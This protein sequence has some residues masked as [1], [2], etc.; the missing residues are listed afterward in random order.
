[1]WE[2]AQKAL[3]AGDVS[4]LGRL[5]QEN[6]LLFRNERPPSHGSGGLAPD[7]AGGDPQSIIVRNRHFENWA[8][9]LEHA[10]ALK[11]KTSQ[12]AQFETAVDAIVTGDTSTLERLLSNNPELVQA[13]STRQHHSTLLHYVGANGVEAFRQETRKTSR[14]SRRCS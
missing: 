11:R 13:R 2:S 5:L 4:T 14:A 7:Y 8:S 12:V 10:Q 1:V 9:F 3:I 6:E